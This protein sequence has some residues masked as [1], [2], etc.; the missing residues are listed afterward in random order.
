[1]RFGFVRNL[2]ATAFAVLGLGPG[3]SWIDV[4]GE[5]FGVRMGWA[6][7]LRAPREAVAYAERVEDPIPLGL[8]IGVHGWRR[9]WAVNTARRPHVVIDFSAPQR[10]TTLGVPMRVQRL[11]LSP[12][13]P[14]SLV[15]ALTVTGRGEPTRPL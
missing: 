4:D 10:A 14:D 6:F 13:D 8:G 9:E 2:T 12:A 7:R 3:S 11:H 15:D 5:R 1:M